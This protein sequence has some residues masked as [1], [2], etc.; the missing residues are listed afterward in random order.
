[1]IYTGLKTS[2][3][4]PLVFCNPSLSSRVFYL[5]GFFSN[6]KVLKTLGSNHTTSFYAC[7]THAMRVVCSADSTILRYSTAAQNAD[8]RGGQRV[9][10]D[11]VESPV[12]LVEEDLH[13]RKVSVTPLDLREYN[14]KQ[15]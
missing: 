10:G 6:D 9:D 1:M 12:N 5:C 7:D 4:L 13:G 11:V 3:R 15:I 2:F 8:V 14:R